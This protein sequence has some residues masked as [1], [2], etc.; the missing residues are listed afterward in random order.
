MRGRAKK[1]DRRA[2][3]NPLLSRDLLRARPR[4][5]SMTSHPGWAIRYPYVGDIALAATMQS[6]ASVPATWIL[7]AFAWGPVFFLAQIAGGLL[8]WANAPD[9]VFEGV[10]T[11]LSVCLLSLTYDL[12]LLVKSAMVWRKPIP[13][14]PSVYVAAIVSVACGAL[15]G[16][17]ALRYVGWLMFIC[18]IPG[19]G[20]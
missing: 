16:W 7:L 9:K 13:A 11:L 14:G 4:K 1:G 6:R 10:V 8:G 17:L 3:P 20:G 19:C 15:S 12:W 18:S 5:P 2:P